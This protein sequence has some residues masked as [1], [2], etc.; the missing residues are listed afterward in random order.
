MLFSIYL[1]LKHPCMG[2]VFTLVGFHQLGVQGFPHIQ[3]LYVLTHIPSPSGV[4][5]QHS[6]TFYC[7]WLIPFSCVL[8]TLQHSYIG[9]LVQCNFT[10][11]IF[12][13]NYLIYVFDMSTSDQQLYNSC[14][15]IIH[16]STS[17]GDV[18]HL[19]FIV[20]FFYRSCLYIYIYKF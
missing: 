5:L 2:L 8:I 3:Q 11:V 19:N 20:L 10:W 18:N 1:S 9:V 14:H 7:H 16:F 6:P 13:L 12:L 17:Q 4:S 15:C